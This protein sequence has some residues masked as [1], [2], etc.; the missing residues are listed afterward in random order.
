L[1][2][3]KDKSYRTAILLS[4]KIVTRIKS[5]YDFIKRDFVALKDP[6]SLENLTALEKKMKNPLISEQAF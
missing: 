4:N 1:R 2:F 3:P 5:Q 6:Q